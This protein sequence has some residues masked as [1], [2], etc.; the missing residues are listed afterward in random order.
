MADAYA[1]VLRAVTAADSDVPPA[2]RAGGGTTRAQRQHTTARVHTALRRPCAPWLQAAE[3]LLRRLRGELGVSTAQHDEA[4]LGA[5][6]AEG[7]SA[8]AAINATDDAATARRVSAACRATLA[9]HT[10]R[11]RAWLCIL[12]RRASRPALTWT[13]AAHGVLSRV[14]RV[15]GAAAGDAANDALA[16]ASV[17]LHARSAASGMHQAPTLTH[18]GFYCRRLTPGAA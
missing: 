2:V 6:V 8:D 4:L 3:R 15:A 10:P 7:V 5:R 11:V 16:T 12:R 14:V 1:A 9:A 13:R 18:M 17:R